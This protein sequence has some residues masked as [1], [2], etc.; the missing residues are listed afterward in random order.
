MAAPLANRSALVLGVANHRSLAWGAAAALH[1][2]GARVALSLASERFRP[3]VERLT[4]GWDRP[5]LVAVAD[6]T[7]DAALDAL[8]A[9]VA[10]ANGGALHAVLHGVAHAPAP[11]LRAPLLECSRADF[12]AAHAVSAYSLVGVARRAAP[13]LRAGGGGSVTA[14]TFAGAQ[15]AA[16]GYGVMG[17]A[18]ASME[19]AARALAA[20]MVRVAGGKGAAVGR[21]RS[22]CDATPTAAGDPLI[23]EGAARCVSYTHPPTS[24]PG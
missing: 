7:D 19:A 15:R 6:V 20:E 1:A 16:P 24:L 9:A 21:L 10:D 3:E 4:A 11:A 23:G 14:L 5:P 2:A 12:L 18:K 17:P 13:L 8:F 22:S